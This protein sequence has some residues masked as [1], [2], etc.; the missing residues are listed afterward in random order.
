M[1]LVSAIVNKSDSKLEDEVYFILFNIL[2]KPSTYSK[3]VG[4]RR[5]GVLPKNFADT[6]CV[7]KIQDSGTDT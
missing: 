2:I 4:A 1:V 5:D 7:Y 3:R 6:K